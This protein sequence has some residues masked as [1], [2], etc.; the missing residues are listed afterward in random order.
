M[1]AGSI[2]RARMVLRDPESLEQSV[3]D[4]EPVARSDSGPASHECPDTAD[5]VFVLPNDQSQ[6]APVVEFLAA[7]ATRA[8]ARDA[9]EQMRISLALDEALVNAL[10][11]GNLEI[12][13]D[14]PDTAQ[15]CRH[16]VAERRSR[17]RPFCN[18]RIRV[19]ASIAHNAAVFVIRDEGRGFDPAR[20]P[21]PTDDANLG[22]CCGR[23]VFLMR[24]LMDDVRFN[25]IGNEVTMVRRW[26]Q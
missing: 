20:L 8:A 16:E 24:S 1:V 11:H 6:I 9:A 5:F 7:Q 17:Q 19:L 21:D 12:Y 13:T 22:R 14:A 10:Y 23:G 4:V 2:S 25:T 3:P 26:A 15:L 18:R